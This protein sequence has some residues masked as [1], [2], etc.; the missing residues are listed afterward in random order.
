[1]EVVPGPLEDWLIDWL[2]DIAIV[3]VIITII[4]PPPPW[5]TVPWQLQHMSVE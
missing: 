5:I 1:M 3:I 2:I 4:I